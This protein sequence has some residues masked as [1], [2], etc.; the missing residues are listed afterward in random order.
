MSK[1]TKEKPLTTSGW[2][3]T[4]SNAYETYYNLLFL[5]KMHSMDMYIYGTQHTWTILF[6]SCLNVH[7]SK[8]NDLSC[9]TVQILYDFSHNYA[10]VWTKHTR[11]R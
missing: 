6:H 2:Y 1:K 4:S 8:Y 3:Q 7:T 9:S 11:L 5:T 10:L